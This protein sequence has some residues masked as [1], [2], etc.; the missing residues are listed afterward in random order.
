MP[1]I[2]DDANWKSWTHECDF[3]RLGE[4]NA[5]NMIEAARMNAIGVRWSPCGYDIALGIPSVVP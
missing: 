2:G 3:R 4:T 1:Y 5:T